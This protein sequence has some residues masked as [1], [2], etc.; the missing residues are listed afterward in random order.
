MLHAFQVTRKNGPHLVVGDGQ[1]RDELQASGRWI[2]S[3]T[4]MEVGR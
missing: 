2:A 4:T 1:T 3:D